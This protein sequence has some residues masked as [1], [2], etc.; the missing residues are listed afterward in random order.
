MKRAKR[1][2]RIFDRI[3]RSLVEGA[4]LPGSD[5]PSTRVLAAELKTSLT[6]VQ[7]A[8]RKAAEQGMLEVRAQQTARV[9]PEGAAVAIR[10]LTQA[11]EASKRRRLAI[12]V[13]DLFT[14]LQV[15]T[16]PFQWRIAHEIALAATAGGYDSEVVPIPDA[17][18]RSLAKRVVRHFDAAFV[19]GMIPTNIATIFVLSESRFPVVLFN[20]H[21]PGLNVPSLNIDE[22]SAARSLAR[23]LLV[24]GHRNVSMVISARYG[25][26]LGRRTAAGGWLECL[27][28]SEAMATC[29][30]PLAHT[31]SAPRGLILEKLLALRPRI[32]GLVLGLPT[33]LHDLAA[34]PQLRDLRIPDDLSLATFGSMHDIP[35]PSRYPPVTSFEVDWNRAG[36]CAIEMIDRMLSGDTQPKDIRVPLNIQLTDSIGLPPAVAE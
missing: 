26:V 23:T 30:M 19:V 3:V 15:T 35:W 32:T 27:E 1:V 21:V 5:L 10:L 36:R 8:L 2:D 24:Q 34:S 6:T 20:R 7:A 9:M 17:D 14:P 16:G 33:L 25:A 18:Q 4:W 29:V 31:Q 12:L 11:A 13:P 22:Y 28:E